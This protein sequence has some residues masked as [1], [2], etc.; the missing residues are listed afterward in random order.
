[1]GARLASLL[2]EPERNGLW[3]R[4]RRVREMRAN[5]A[6]RAAGCPDMRNPLAVLSPKYLCVSERECV[7]PA[8]RI[9]F[10]SGASGSSAALV[11]AT[12]RADAADY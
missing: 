2:C 9:A 12:V 4:S 1:M 3:M 5:R 11:M 10:A 7:A 8:L 6:N